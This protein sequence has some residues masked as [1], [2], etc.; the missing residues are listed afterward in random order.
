M[1][2][3]R[4]KIFSSP[5]ISGLQNGKQLKKF[6]AILIALSALSFSGFS[7]AASADTYT[8]GTGC[9]V[10][11]SHVASTL[12]VNATLQSVT[13]NWCYARPAAT[14]KKATTVSSV[15]FGSWKGLNQT[16]SYS[17]ASL[18]SGWSVNSGGH[19]VGTRNF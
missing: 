18:G 10:A 5:T 14:C 3:L 2:L 19:Q 8:P 13:S 12:I 4:K 7:S 16:S 6:I 15:K 9:G 11:T 1:A 17:C